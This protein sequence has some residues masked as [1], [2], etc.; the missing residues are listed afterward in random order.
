[1]LGALRWRSNDL[2]TWVD[3]EFIVGDEQN[4]S[5][6]DVQA[7]TSRLIATAGQFKQQHSLNGWHAFDTRW[8]AGAEVVYGRQA[9]D[10]HPDTVD[11]INGPGFAGAHWWGVNTSI[12]YRVRDD[13]AFSL[14]AEHF[15][16]PQG[17]ALFPVSVAQGAFNALT[18]GLR[19]EATRN[20]PLR[21]ELRYDRF[22]GRAEDHPFGN[23]RDRAQT[24]ATVQALL[25]F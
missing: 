4:Q 21:P 17:F 13:L 7:P 24:T 2:R 11:I 18:I 3:Y 8:S 16:D 14:R 22:S 9:G 6:A 20:L 15:D 23:G 19:Y 12:S 1:M 10:G 5:F 25:Y